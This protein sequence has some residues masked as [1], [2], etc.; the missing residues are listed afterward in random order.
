MGTAQFI[1][2][3]TG[4]LLP[5][6]ADIL[7]LNLS[8]GGSGMTLQAFAGNNGSARLVNFDVSGTASFAGQSFLGA[9]TDGFLSLDYGTVTLNLSN[10]RT[11]AILNVAP[12]DMQDATDLTNANTGLAADQVA[13]VGVTTDATSF[14]VSSRPGENGLQV[15]EMS[16]RSG[17]IPIDPAPDPSV[18]QFSDL[19]T[20]TAYGQTWILGTSLTGEN[21]VSYT[22]DA[23][24]ALTPQFSFGAFEGLG[25]NT[26]TDLNIVMLEGQPHVVLASSDSNS[27]SVLR[28]EADGSFTPTDHILD[29]LNTR[30]AE[31]TTLETI[32]IDDTT[33]VL[34]AGSDDGFS[35]FQLL[36][37]GRLHHL[38]TVADTAL[39][40]LDNVSAAAMGMDGTDLRMFFASG[41][42]VG[43]SQFSYDLSAL[44][45]NI[46]GTSTA[47]VLNGT[48]LNDVILA[49]AG[50]DTLIGGAGN[51]ILVD[52]AG[53]DT[54]IGG[55]GS[56]VFTFEADGDDD[57]IQ[58]FER[59][60]DA[61]D[62]SYFPL[63]YDP[64][65]LGF[66]STAYGASLTF[67]G[68]TIF[69]Q[70][71]DF[72]PLTLAELTAIHPFNVDRPALV[73][74][75]GS[76]GNGQTQI[77][78]GAN[79][80]LVGT[81]GDDM[82]SGNGGDDTLIGGAGADALFGG[83]G[84]DTA[85]YGTATTGIVF[86]WLNS[87]LNTGDAA[88]DTLTSIEVILAT[89]FDDHISGSNAA[90][91]LF[92]RNGADTLNGRAGNDNLDGGF[93]NDIL[94]GGDGA[95]ALNGGDQI[96]TA[97]Y[98]DAL[99]GLHIDLSYGDRNTGQAAGDTY[100]SIED[101][102][103]SDFSDAVYGDAGVNTIY[104]NGGDDWLIG[105]AGNDVIYGG[106]GN[107]VLDG[108]LGAD[109]LDGGAGLDRVNYYNSKQGLTASLGNSSLNSG[110]AAGD[111]YS[112]IED[113]AGS[114]FDDLIEGNSGDNR[115]IANAGDD[116]LNGLSGNDMLLGGRGADR[117]NGGAGDD[118]LFGD[119]GADIFVFKDGFDT[120]RIHDF[121]TSRD[122][123][124][125]NTAL[126]GA[127]AQTGDA[128][129][130]D[131]ASI[132]GTTVTLD[133]GNGDTLII[134]HINALSDISDAFIFV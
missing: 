125:L 96:D 82:L 128:V 42:E 74:G 111:S 126:L 75:N 120:D 66:I 20:V 13:M 134:D 104:G 88:G 109:F 24:G 56:D 51:D 89:G 124:E 53:S 3:V 121:E 99:S 50:D 73:L 64:N 49:G 93:G 112:S 31:V 119:S 26:P 37:D 130:N 77:G 28:L 16:Q 87:A 35:L 43:I 113:L 21:V 127:T 68:E 60:I 115:L 80:T 100:A 58:D 25:I 19:A 91:A 122:L 107:D 90:D 22:I 54:M 85:N 1:E 81:T 92:G 46:N 63:L 123:I 106:N 133:F 34:A 108:G 14:L 114:R 101:L 41:T 36:N 17:L 71:S 2:T 4:P 72:N 76:T 67:Q 79:D 48:S 33:F 78:A 39:Y 97:S 94:N 105:R 55:A 27:L 65:T 7:D 52:G 98:I 103:G 38:T 110:I 69:I 129:L 45:A 5:Y 32:T 29:D 116:V 131:Y 70:S 47:D 86:D 102:A 11:D 10:D 57:T 8:V 59:G 84:Y 6:G 18:G 62:L 83:I 95:D 30:F 117:L 40:S 44:G 12:G 132:T 23:V 61:L 15:F 118:N 9:A